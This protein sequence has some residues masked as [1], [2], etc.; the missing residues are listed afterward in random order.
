[1]RC[2][3]KPHLLGFWR[4]TK[5]AVAVE[6]A[7]L[8]TI[9]LLLIAGVL[10]FGHAW[11]MK[12]VITNASREGARYG[13]TYQTNTSGVRIAP[14]ALNPT[15]QAYIQNNYLANAALPCDA[16]PT[17]ILEGAGYTSGTKGAGLEVTVTATKTWFIISSFVPGMGEQQSLSAKT[18]MLCE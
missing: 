6:F 11:Y 10:D 4:Q 7:I 1:M 15:I 5:G 17:I 16:N 18:V 14:N 2:N 9:F 8:S 12:Q 13:I 3:D